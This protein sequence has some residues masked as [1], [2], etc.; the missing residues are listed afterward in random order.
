MASEA[1]QHGK[2]GVEN[3]IDP[4]EQRPC[5]V[6]LQPKLRFGQDSL[7]VQEDWKSDKPDDCKQQ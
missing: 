4:P 2:E 6:Q 7:T 3:Q 5:A 1:Q